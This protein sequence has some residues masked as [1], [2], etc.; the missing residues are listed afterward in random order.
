MKVGIP[1]AITRANMDVERH[2][3]SWEHAS[4]SIPRYPGSGLQKSYDD[5]THTTSHRTLMHPNSV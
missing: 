1:N 5:H 4:Y 3:Q 2:R